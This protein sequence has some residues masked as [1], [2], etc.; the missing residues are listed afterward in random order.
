VANDAVFVDHK[1]NAVGKEAGEIEDTASLGHL[2][3]GVGKQWKCGAG[4]FS[5]LAVP[6]LAVEADPQNLCACGLELGDITLI[7][8][9]LFRSTGC[10]SANIK[11]QD[12]G[13]LAPEVRELDGLAALVRQYKVRSAVAD[14]QSRR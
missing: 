13:L 7:R 6:F 12:N 8:L 14:F 11:R 10:G 2:L 9:D 5:K 1:R 3:L 4:F